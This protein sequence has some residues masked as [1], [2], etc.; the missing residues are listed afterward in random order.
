MPW[1]QACRV[2]C[3]RVLICSAL[4]GIPVCE[5]WRRWISECLCAQI[6]S[7]SL[8]CR[9]VLYPVLY[10]TVSCRTIPYHAVPHRTLTAYCTPSGASLSHMP[11]V[12]ACCVC[13]S[14]GAVWVRRC[15]LDVTGSRFDGNEAQ[16]TGGAVTIT[17]QEKCDALLFQVRANVLLVKGCAFCKHARRAYVLLV[18]GARMMQAYTPTQACQGL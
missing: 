12:A 16:D 17:P 1:L 4:G 2:G 7:R 8:A 6:A 11:C 15:N 14:G 10:R 18:D 3:S 13:R 5:G 9:T